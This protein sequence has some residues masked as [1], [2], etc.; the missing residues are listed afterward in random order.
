MKTKFSHEVII[1]ILEQ[2]LIYQ[3]ACPAQVCKSI[4]ELR[5]LYAYQ[6]S[7]LNL[8]DIDRAIHQSIADAVSLCHAEME[9]CLETIL[10][11]EKWDMNTYEMPELLKNRI[12]QQFLE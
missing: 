2:S 1:R 9:K 6:Q 3:C 8:T 12:L 10:T 7:C 5:A 11:L 4:N